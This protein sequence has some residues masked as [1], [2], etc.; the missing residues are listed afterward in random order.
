MLAFAGKDLFNVKEAFNCF[1]ADVISQ[2]AFGE[3]MG[4]VAQK[5]WEPNFA[6]WVKPFFWSAYAMR[7]NGIAKKIAQVMPP[8]ANYLGNDIRATMRILNNTIPRYINGALQDSNTGRVFAS[9][10]STDKHLS[11]EEKYRL[12]GEGFNLLLAGT[13]TTAVSYHENHVAQAWLNTLMRL[14]YTYYPYLLATCQAACLSA[15]H[16]WFF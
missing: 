3:P 13:E 14:G 7:H 16:V 10:M 15:P 6:I 4:F 1:T 8:M 2:Y 9:L 12:W 5:G 11:K